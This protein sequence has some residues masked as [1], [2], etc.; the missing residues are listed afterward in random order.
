MIDQKAV[1]AE[2]D[3]LIAECKALRQRAKYDDYSDLQESETVSMMTSIASAVRRLAP[4]KSQ[5]PRR[6]HRRG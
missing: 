3:G 4:P 6:S 2:L 1:V 5:G